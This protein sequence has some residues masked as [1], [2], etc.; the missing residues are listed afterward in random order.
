M[1][2][3]L[4]ARRAFTLVE[5]LVVIAIIGV[6]VGLLLPAV[7]K[8]REAAARTQCLNNLKQIGLAAHSYHDAKKVFPQNYRPASAASSTVRVRWFTR[9][10]PYLE[11]DQ[12]H[13]RYDETT[14]W[15]SATNLPVTSTY[16]KIAS[17]PSAPL[18]NRFDVNP[19]G[20]AGYANPPIVAVTDYAGVYGVH[21]SFISA[22]SSIPT[23]A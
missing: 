15:D 10:L 13:N 1:K 19:S 16:L 14:N 17:C 6:L 18:P 8:V 22:N 21:P 11:Q 3:H 12:L 5:L 23:I 7:Q 20:G 4:S 2:S 9:L